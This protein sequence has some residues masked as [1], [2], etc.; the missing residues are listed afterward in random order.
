MASNGDQ[1][2]KDR[3]RSSKTPDPRRLGYIRV[4]TRT[5][6]PDRQI[7]VLRDQCDELH[8]EHVSAIASER[9][10]FDELL[11]DLEPGDTFVVVDLDR[12]FR[13]A[14]DAILTSSALGQRGIKFR[15]LSFPLDTTSDEG[16]LF[17]GIVALFAQFERRIIS[18][19][20]REGLDAARARGVTLGRRPKLTEQEVR[21]AYDQ[22]TTTN[23]KEIASRLGVARITLQRSFRRLGL[24]YPVHA[25]HS[26][27]GGPHA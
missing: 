17:F 1:I 3:F 23:C 21:A 6:A 14:V 10:V 7:E 13:S 16:E 25:A 27:N 5:Q 19:R 11:A 8:I 15:I 22:L 18:R 2:G 12:A 24:H 4:S 26:N 9:P 20:T